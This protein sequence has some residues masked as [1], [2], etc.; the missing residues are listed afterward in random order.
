M[1]D[2]KP[3]TTPPPTAWELMVYVWYPKVK[4][5]ATTNFI[6]MRAL[7]LVTAEGMDQ[8]LRIAHHHLQLVYLNHPK[9]TVFV[10]AAYNACNAIRS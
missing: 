7:V 10:K 1:M 5:E 4:P 2:T 8:I 6:S 9:P 3:I